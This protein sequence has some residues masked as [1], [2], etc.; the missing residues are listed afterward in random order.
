MVFWSPFLLDAMAGLRDDA[1]PDLPGVPRDPAFLARK[2]GLVGPLARA[3]RHAGAVRDGLHLGDHGRRDFGGA[4][5]FVEYMM[6]DGYLRWLALSPQG[7]YPV[8]FGD[9]PIPSAT[10]TGWAGLQSGVERKAPLRR[11]YSEGSIESIGD[12]ARSFQRWGFEQ[13]GAALVG[14]LRE[15]GAGRH[16]DRAR[17]RPRRERGAGGARGTGRGG[18]R[19]GEARAVSRSHGEWNRAV[20]RGVLVP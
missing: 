17:D 11:Y 3:G 2:S 18:G 13:G 12:G 4:Q 1:V 7:K 20:A 14:A 5:R 15:L 9:R 10:S 6:S 16:G 19:R 8:R